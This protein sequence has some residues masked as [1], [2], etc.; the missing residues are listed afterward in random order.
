MTLHDE[1][2]PN[3]SMPGDPRVGGKPQRRRRLG[4]AL[5]VGA[6]ALTSACRSDTE[7]GDSVEPTSDTSGGTGSTDPTAD[8]T[9]ATEDTT[10]SEVCERLIACA[11]ALGTVPLSPL[12]ESYG[13][14]GSCWSTFEVAVCSQ[15]C[16]SALLPLSAMDP[17]LAACLECEQDDNCEYISADNAC[18]Q[19]RCLPVLLGD[20]S[21]GDPC[22]SAEDC[23]VGECRLQDSHD[24][25]LGWCTYACEAND[26]CPEPMWFCEQ[27]RQRCWPSS[28]NC[29]PLS[30]PVCHSALGC[31]WNNSAGAC[32][33]FD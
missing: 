10:P 19:G 23:S 22:Y 17:G 1:R 30:E 9:G 31:Q 29:A 25:V 32:E 15:D 3:H 11:T 33:G 28:G 26:D 2:R 24:G 8:D 13:P 21:L 14:Q 12:V 7:Q 27:S 16:R 6:F 5:L 18:Y 20:G 4:A